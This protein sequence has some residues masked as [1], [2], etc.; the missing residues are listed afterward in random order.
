MWFPIR[1]V[2]RGDLAA[3]ELCGGHYD[4]EKKIWSLPRGILALLKAFFFEHFPQFKS[5]P[6]GNLYREFE[7][8][9]ERHL[10]VTE[11]PQNVA[12]F[13]W[14]L[15]HPCGMVTAPRYPIVS[16][17]VGP[18]IGWWVASSWDVFWGSGRGPFFFSMGW[19][20]TCRNQWLSIFWGG[21]TTS[22]ASYLEL[23]QGTSVFA[24]T[25]FIVFFLQC[26]SRSL[27]NWWLFLP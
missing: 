25:H 5:R 27:M 12:I 4:K 6:L 15:W 20:K 9:P 1:N 16:Q 2:H 14:H 8:I 23:H 24:H 3:D 11:K 18:S 21:W 19:V 17:E 7:E 26:F 10:K 13:L 22:C